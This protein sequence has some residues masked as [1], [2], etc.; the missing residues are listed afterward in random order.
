MKKTFSLLGGLFLGLFISISIIA[1]GEN[2]LEAPDNNSSSAATP[3][4]P[5]KVTKIT[6]SEEGDSWDVMS[7]FNYDAKG[8]IASCKADDMSWNITI[9]D[10]QITITI[11][12][13][14]EVTKYIIAGENFDK[15]SANDI[16]LL[17]LDF[18]FGESM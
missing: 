1:C 9:S 8:R 15:Q 17:L 10:T 4:V 16:N 18:M 11:T 14:D 5:F 3:E 2:S 12:Y 6:F 7:N 13:E